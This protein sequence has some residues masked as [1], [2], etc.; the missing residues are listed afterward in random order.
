LL[1]NLGSEGMVK[2]IKTG[3]FCIGL[4]TYW[5]QFSGLLDNLLAVHEKIAGKLG[6]LGAEI[7]DA[8]MIDNPFKAR[9][10]AELFNRNGVE[11]IVL[12]I[13][14]YAL[15]HN[16]LPL[17]QRTSAPLLVLNLQ[18]EKTLDFEK[19]NSTGD[20]GKMTGEWL[21]LCQSCVTPELA[22]V[23]NRAGIKYHLI[24][25]YLDAE[26]VW[27]E[28]GEWT[29]ACAVKLILRNTRVGVLGHYYNGMLD[30]YSDIS[31][32]STVFGCHFELMEFGKLKKFFDIATDKEIEE[33]VRQFRSWFV[34]SPECSEDDLNDA[35]R[36][37]TALDRIVE[38]GSLGALAFYYEGEDDINYEKVV[39]T[40]IPGMT[41]L[42][43]RN[44][45]VA[46][47]CEIK[48]VLAMKIM[49]SF[50]CGGSFS[51]FYLVDYEKDEILLGH[52]GPAHY[53]IAEG[54]PGLIPLPLFHGKPGKGL[55]IQMKVTNGPVTLLSVCQGANGKI[56]LLTAEGESVPGP[57]MQI[58]NTNSRYKFS[59]AASEFINKWSM[60]GPSHHCAIGV[61][62]ISEKL[63]KLAALLNIDFQRVC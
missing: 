39:T 3:L 6:S 61:G 52:D 42:T 56:S 10:A 15:S 50:G 11:L 27:K 36:G 53:K 19:F 33:K 1:N 59:I 23:F 32:L 58:A 20:R 7:I 13:S 16:V 51:E 29:G 17:L 37:S 43:G 5:G 2:G 35:A 41:L 48:N 34:V 62:H 9:S 47:E 21:S 63:N 44:I 8:G 24:S 60:A 45:P 38:S 55:S 54:R 49:D 30:V 22:S 14:T 46:G 26:S 40:L 18:P 25:G 4:E 12:N 28:I 57:T 31:M